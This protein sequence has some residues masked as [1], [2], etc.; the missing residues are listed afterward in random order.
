[1]KNAKK[2]YY[3]AVMMAVFFMLGFTVKSDE[4]RTTVVP[5][6][7][8]VDIPR[9]VTAMPKE[10]TSDPNLF[11]L[12]PPQV[13]KSFIGFKEALAYRESRGD[14]FIVNRFGYMGKYQFGKSALQFYGV[15]DAQQFLNS[16]EQQER[17][18]T[19]SLQ[20]NKWYLRNEIKQYVGT[21]INGIEVTESGILAA[22][23]LVGAQSVK[24]YLKKK[25]RYAFAD[26]NGTTLQ[27]Y[28]RH[29]AGYD[30]AHI[31]PEKLPRF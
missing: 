11:S 13:G 10:I 3:C 20:R 2:R 24:K 5:P 23:H 9:L 25:G 21:K 17:L 4:E 12:N 19:L 16:P 18:F 14:Y 15:K 22:A 6:S 27:N 31:I 7:F 8:V 28:L 1:M 26:G 30:T 29:F